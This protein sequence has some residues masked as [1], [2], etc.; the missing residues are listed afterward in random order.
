[1][2]S[3]R[4]NLLGTS[5]SA[6]AKEDDEYLK[7]LLSYYREITG[8]VEKNSKSNN[9][10]EVSILSGITLVDE[11][12]KEKKKNAALEK[13]LSTPQNLEEERMTRSMIEKLDEALTFTSGE[14]NQN[15][16]DK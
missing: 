16:S 8:A 3:I 1:M 2:G 5:F 15:A 10:L 6:S 12:Y 14:N 9:P 7:K 13:A 11:L 4:I